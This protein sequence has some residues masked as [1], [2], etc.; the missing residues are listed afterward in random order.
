MAGD[1]DEFLTRLL[2]TF[3]AEA[4]EHVEAISSALVSLQHATSAEQ[5]ELLERAFREA[6]SLKGAARAV[7]FTGIESVC[8]SL[9]AV[10]AAWKS[11][12]ITPDQT[13]FELLHEAVDRIPSM[14]ATDTPQ[15]TSN[16]S[17]EALL[18]RL[19]AAARA[20]A[21]EKE[22]DARPPGKIAGDRSPRESVAPE[23]G[24]VRIPTVKIESIMRQAEELLGPRLSAKQRVEELQAIRAALTARRR[25]HDALSSGGNGPGQAPEET[26]D[27]GLQRLA[28]Y[29]SAQGEFLDGLAKMV[30]ELERHTRADDHAL[31]KLVDG[32]LQGV[33]DTQLLPFATIVEGLRRMVRDLARDRG[34]QIDLVITG[35]EIEIDR[36]ILDEMRSPLQH[37]LRNAVDHGIEPVSIRQQ[38]G[39]PARGAVRLAIQHKQGRIEIVLSDD[40]AGIDVAAVRAAAGTIPGAAG[41]AATTDDGDELSLIFQSGLSTS[42]RIDHISGRGLGLAVVREKIDRLG[43]TVAVESA[44]GEGTTFRIALPLTMATLRGILVSERG[45]RFVVPAVAVERVI[46]T[47]VAQIRTVEQRRTI[48]VDAHPVPLVRL[49][50]ALDLTSGE[51][52]ADR[53][54]KAVVI[55]NGSE[56]IALVVDEILAEQEVL[57]K[58]LGPLL[59]RVRNVAGA[60]VLGT[61]EVV[62]VLSVADLLKS[63]S[64]SRLPAASSPEATVGGTGRRSILIAEDSITSRALLKNILEGAGYDVTVAVDGVD[65]WTTLRTRNFD[66]VVSDVEMPRMSGFEL[67]EK[68]RADASLSDLPVIL[69][70]ALATSEHRERGI[71]AGAN[72]YLAKRSFEQAD[73]LEAIRRLI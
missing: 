51:M 63:M 57:V 32:L 43:G 60:S 38:R 36:R 39:K 17:I 48:I 59:V 67:T 64:R 10:F 46:R 12:R 72:A 29:M 9:E 47:E 2:A 53:Y 52:Y 26:Q 44:Q 34:R 14:L 65:A 62:P 21:D 56:R 37:L 50:H 16:A 40:G 6:H 61:G 55:G 42:A 41:Q 24:T 27:G 35:A 1:R 31:G 54:A 8:H 28:A 66:L 5:S 19:D 11:G 18:R 58:S 73:L 45:K 13:L 20:R 33:K 71:D 25:E 7:S 49:S 69:V 4:S 22:R 15:S 30:D 70:T 3:G 23:P 68:I